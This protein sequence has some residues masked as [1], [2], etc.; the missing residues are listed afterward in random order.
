MLATSQ[1]HATQWN[2]PQKISASLE[3]VWKGSSLV[4]YPSLSILKPKLLKALQYCSIPGL[5]SGIFTMYLQHHGSQQ[6][7]DRAKTILF[8]A[9]WVLYVLTAATAIVDVILVTLSF[10]DPVSMDDHR[11][12]TFF[13]IS[14]TELHRDSLPP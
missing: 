9:L 14:C 13:S 5:Y 6:S 11:C 1:T 2:L 4:R 12:L 8:Y 10:Y 3:R 7:T